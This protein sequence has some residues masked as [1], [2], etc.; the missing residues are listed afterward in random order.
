[1]SETELT[2]HRRTAGRTNEE[3]HERTKGGGVYG[4]RCMCMA[5]LLGH[6]YRDRLQGEEAR[7]K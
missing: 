5:V 6:I 4:G 7:H 1:M 3:Q 2:T